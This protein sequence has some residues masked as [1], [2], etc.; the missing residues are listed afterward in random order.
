M[1]S[2]NSATDG[3][4]DVPL[5]SID[6]SIPSED[7]L[8]SQLEDFFV[9]SGF[10]YNRIP[11]S[12]EERADFSVER[13]GEKTLLELKILGDDLEEDRER[14]STLES[15]NLYTYTET[16]GYR[17]AYSKKIRKGVSQLNATPGSFSYKI[18]WLHAAGHYADHHTTRLRSTIYGMQ[19][20]FVDGEDSI[21]D[22][23]YFHHSEFFKN[24]T[25]LDA[26][27]ISCGNELEFWIN[28][29]ATSYPKVLSS[30]IFDLLEDAAFDPTS[31]ERE[32]RVYRVDG[33]VNRKDRESLLT[34]IEDK[35]RCGNVQEIDM[36]Q[37]TVA[38]ALPEPN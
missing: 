16:A 19:K 29:L 25:T 5:N 14:K 30:E 1:S 27:I 13:C 23:H 20:L 34:H 36:A 3:I 21:M 18:I 28:D 24:R 33:P 35:Y 12:V 37:H 17:N 7:D 26:A 9:S 6:F 15:G 8:L 10:E 32:G 2:S 38:A 11:E 4:R 31:F 22:C